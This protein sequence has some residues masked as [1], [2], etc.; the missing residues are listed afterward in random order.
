[1]RSIGLDWMNTKRA[2]V[3]FI[4]LLYD[5]DDEIA[6]SFGQPLFPYLIKLLEYCLEGI[7][8]TFHHYSLHLISHFQGIIFCIFILE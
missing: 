7:T 1:M 4:H 2:Y 8:K 3:A 5:D 6:K